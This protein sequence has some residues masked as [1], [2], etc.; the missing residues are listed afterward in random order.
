MNCFPQQKFPAQHACFL[1]CVV[2]KVHM[3]QNIIFKGI[4]I[5]QIYIP[6]HKKNKNTTF[7]PFCLSKSSKLNRHFSNATE[8]LQFFMQNWPISGHTKYELEKRKINQCTLVLIL[9]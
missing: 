2:H 8:I 3:A 6:L 4:V 5:L 1:L 7:A 9:F